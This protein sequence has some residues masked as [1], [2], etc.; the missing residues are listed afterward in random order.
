MMSCLIAT[1]RPAAARAKYAPLNSFDSGSGAS[2]L[3]NGCCSGFFASPQQAAEAARIVEAHAQTRVE[4][5]VDVIVQRRCSRA[6][7]QPQAARHSKVQDHRAALEIEQ[8][9]LR[10]AS[11]LAQALAGGLFR[12]FA[13][14]APAQPGREPGSNG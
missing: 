14:H 9:V 1:L 2:D 11:Q 12:Q 8:Q 4:H 6:R 5:D 13:R 10:A 3:S 7:Q